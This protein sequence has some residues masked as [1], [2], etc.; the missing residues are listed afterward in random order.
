MLSHQRVFSLSGRGS[1]LFCVP[2]SP[3]YKFNLTAYTD[4][5]TALYDFTFYLYV[6]VCWWQ[7]CVLEVEVT[8]GFNM[9]LNLTLNLYYYYYYYNTFFV[10]AFTVDHKLHALD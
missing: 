10:M 7:A 8:D 4:L 9:K 6:H 3:F 5:I 2:P 1:S